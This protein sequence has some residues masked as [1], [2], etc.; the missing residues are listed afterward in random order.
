MAYDVTNNTSTIELVESPDIPVG[1]DLTP[2]ELPAIVPSPQLVGSDAISPVGEIVE[3]P[4]TLPAQQLIAV[5]NVSPVGDVIEL[6]PE[7]PPEGVVLLEVIPIPN[8]LDPKKIC[9]PTVPDTGVDR[10]EDLEDVDTSGRFNGYILVYNEITDTYVHEPKPSGIPESTF[11]SDITVVLSG[12]KTFGKYRNGDVI[13]ALGK[14]AVEVILLATV[15]YISATFT[16]FSVTGQASTVEV[17]TTVSGSKTFTW[18]ITLNS[19]AVPTI[20]VYDVTAASN[21]ITDTPNDGSESSTIVTVQLNSN[22]AN[23]AWRGIGTDIT[24]D[25]DVIFNSSNFTITGRYFRFYGYASAS[26]TDSLTVRALPQSSYQT[27]NSQSFNLNTGSLLTKFVVALPP[28]RTISQVI[29]LDALNTDITTEYIIQPSINV[30]DAGG[31]SRVYNVYEMNI[32]VPYS[33]THRHQI[34]TA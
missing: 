23:Q 10:L 16:S 4:K 30:V 5:D 34:T 26:P 29:D 13:P 20:T 18:N 9:C 33:A 14:T 31:T 17:G 3:L 25:P 28:G 12:G 7:L 22:G 8:F 19:G 1:S 11:S 15:E 24:P 21:L 6:P 32:G 27:S 2:I